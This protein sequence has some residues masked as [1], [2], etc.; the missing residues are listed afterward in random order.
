MMRR[1]LGLCAGLLL[2]GA[3]ADTHDELHWRFA[4]EE[5]EG[6]VQHAYA[7]RFA[8]LMAEKTAGAVHVDIYP[9]G[10][11]GTS[12]E[13]TQLIQNR[14][15][16]LAFAS[17]GHLGTVVPESQVFLLPF[18]FSDDEDINQQLLTSRGELH[19]LLQAAYQQRQLQLLSLIPEG[20]MV[21]SSDRPLRSPD[22]FRGF[23]IRTMTSPL[24]LAA[25]GAFGAS[26]TP[27]PYAEVYGALQLNMI[28]GQVNP[29]FAIE[30][31][32]FYEQQ[33]YLIFPNHLPFVASLV[34]HPAFYADLA[35]ELRSALDATVH[36]LEDYIHQ[37]QKDF[38]RERL[39]RILER[40]DMQ[41]IYL[42]ETERAPFRQA[43]QQ[44]RERFVRDT[45][46]QGERILATLQAQLALLTADTSNTNAAEQDTE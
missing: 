22:D 31:M 8:E 34:A 24:L 16:Q 18:T 39:A 23:R 30:E 13:L 41:L 15:I 38:N 42:D 19:E 10:A 21:W 1:L 33:D 12:G 35:P 2:L 5:V 4:L 25:Y 6:S 29:V 40:K 45:G 44:V 27:L 17:P 11:L 9:Y 20:W 28:D 37:V 3:C 43:S 32:S 46:P 26:P 7:V 36:E 14:A